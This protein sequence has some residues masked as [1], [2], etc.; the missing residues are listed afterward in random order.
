MNAAVDDE[1][2][3]LARRASD[4]V[5]AQRVQRVDA[6]ADHVARGDRRHV[7]L[8]ERLVDDLRIAVV[9]RRRRRQHVEPTGRNTRRR[10]R[11]RRLD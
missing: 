11:T 3:A 7:D 5:A 9:T 2:A 1:G 6:D 8:L 4:F 10:R